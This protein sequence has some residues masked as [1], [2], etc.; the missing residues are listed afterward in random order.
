MSHWDFSHG[1]S[2]SLLPG[3]TRCDIVASSNLQ[4]MLDFCFCLFVCVCV[5]VCVCA[6]V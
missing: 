4:C 1:Q 6:C 2:G 5:C 3:A